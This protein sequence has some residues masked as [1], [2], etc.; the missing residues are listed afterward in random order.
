MMIVKYGHDGLRHV[1]VREATRANLSTLA[2]LKKEQG[3]TVAW[4]TPASFE[5]TRDDAA[6]GAIYRVR[7]DDWPC[8]SGEPI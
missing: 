3:W 2:K 5:I 6:A 7:P 8:P 1:A 4:L